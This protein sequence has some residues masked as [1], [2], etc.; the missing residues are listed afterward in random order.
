METTEEWRTTR[1]Y[2][3]LTIYNIYTNDHDQ[4]VHDG[5]FI[6]ADDLYIIAQYPIF[7]QVQ[8]TIEEALGELIEYDRNNSGRANPDKMQ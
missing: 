2:S 1:E 5:T 6:Y 4:S 8:N 3:P 7:S